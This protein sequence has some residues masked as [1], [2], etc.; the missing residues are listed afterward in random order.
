[1]F[2]TI[3]PCTLKIV[4][5]ILSFF[6]DKSKK[7]YSEDFIR[8]DN[9]LEILYVI[10]PWLIP[11]GIF[12]YFGMKIMRAYIKTQIKWY[13]DIK[14]VSITKLLMIYGIIGTIFYTIICIITTFT[15]CSKAK[16]NDYFCETVGDKDKKYFAS[17]KLYFKD[18][19]LQFP[20]Q[21]IILLTIGIL[22]F[23]FYKFFSLMIIK[24][25]TPIH[26][27]FSLPL[28]YIMR[29]IILTISFLFDTPEYNTYILKYILD[30][31]GDFLCIFAYLIYL[32][33]IELH[34]CNLNFNLSENII[35]RG[36]TE[37]YPKEDLINED[38]ESSID[39]GETKN[40]LSSND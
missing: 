1:M 28:F 4:T 38:E 22:G 17:F 40:S 33:I 8:K 36:Q 3:L 11:I 32:E 15:E 6:D 25:L 7:L 10:Y 19:L 24:N 34:C 27:V 16:I 39:R 18:I 23:S 31:V 13:M 14:Y 37:L 30:V 35:T 20:L 29:K 2:L 9:H 5:I 26:L 21:E 12:I